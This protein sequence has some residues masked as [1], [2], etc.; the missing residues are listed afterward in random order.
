[1]GEMSIVKPAKCRLMVDDE[2]EYE[3]GFLNFGLAA[4]CSVASVACGVMSVVDRNNADKW[5]AASIGLGI[6][7]AV[8]SFGVGTAVVAA[9][10]K[11]GGS[12]ATKCATIMGGTAGRQMSS[13]AIA[14]GT[15]RGYQVA[16][17]MGITAPCASVK[18]SC[19]AYRFL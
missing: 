19:Y 8:L 6:A 4:V 11:I 1:M 5:N 12:F 16:Y 17:T 13:G 14:K 3:G 9:G 15:Y 7:G 18:G 2:M 10:S